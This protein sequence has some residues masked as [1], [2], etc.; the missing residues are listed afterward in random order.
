MPATILIALMGLEIG[1]AETHAVVLSRHLQ[2]MGYQVVMASSGGRYEAEIAS[3][4]IRHYTV[5]LDNSRLCSMWSSI[6]TIRRLL[7][8]EKIDLIHAHARIPA[9]VSDWARFGTGVPMITTA[10]ARFKSPLHLRY[11]SRWGKKVI[12]VSPDIR[13]H[14]IE[15]YRVSPAQI[16]LIYNGI[17]VEVF[18]PDRP[19]LTEGA[20]KDRLTL[21]GPRLLYLSRLDESLTPVALNLIEAVRR[22]YP[23][24]P[25]LQLRI[26]G[27]GPGQETVI[28]RIHE[29]Q[30]RQEPHQE[31]DQEPETI[32]FL[33]ALPWVHQAMLS[34]DLVIG[35]SR[36]AL[37]AMACAR[38]VI[39]AGGEGFAGLI[40]PEHLSAYESDNFT[41]RQSRTPSTVERIQAALQQFLQLTEAERA[42]IGRQLRQYIV[43]HYSSRQMARETA[44]VYQQ[45]LAEK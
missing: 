27:E 6:R 40:Q 9:F 4:G 43:D 20:E 14:L 24:Y 13:T 42:H 35:V 12:A 29:I 1:G 10:H 8:Q 5:P 31:R 37:E 23:A 34:S 28:A 7:Q 15:N 25:G 45:V 26:A 3:Y 22:L 30:Q 44:E 32:Q 33:G 38:N 19:E 16:Q 18:N 41:G 36:V 2:E 39:L 21:T 17:D 11:L